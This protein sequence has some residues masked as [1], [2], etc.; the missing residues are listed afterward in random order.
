MVSSGTSHAGTIGDIVNM[1]EAAERS[2]QSAFMQRQVAMIRLGVWHHEQM[3]ALGVGTTTT[4][5]AARCVMQRQPAA[6]QHCSGQ[7]PRPWRNNLKAAERWYQLYV[8]FKIGIITF[9]IRHAGV[10]M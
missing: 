7:R 4:K 5:H 10:P 6:H 3:M 1:V 9:D 2:A 8:Y